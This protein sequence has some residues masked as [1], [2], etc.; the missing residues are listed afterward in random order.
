MAKR[1]RTT[2]A[3]VPTR[4]FGGPSTLKISVPRASGLARP[5]K[6]RHRRRASGGGTIADEKGALLGAAVLG[7][8]DKAGTKVPTIPVLGRAGT[9]A[10]AA[11]YGGK[12][13]HMPMV[14][15][16]A[17]GFACIALYEFM[18]DGKIAGVDGDVDGVSTV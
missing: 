16:A 4:S 15:R 1:R 12:Q 3:I 10:I 8:L 13:F 14:K 9:L 7:Y 17:V 6:T 11:Y 5:K 2:T 18:R